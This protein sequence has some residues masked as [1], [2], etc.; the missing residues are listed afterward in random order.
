MPPKKKVDDN[1]FAEVK[2]L[3]TSIAQAV[4]SLMEEVRR[5]QQQQPAQTQQQQQ[6]QPAQTQWQLQQERVRQEEMQRLLQAQ[7]Q[8]RTGLEMEQQQIQ[9][10]REQREQEREQREQEQIQSMME[11]RK[12]QREERE[13]EEEFMPPEGDDDDTEAQELMDMMDEATNQPD[14]LDDDEEEELIAQLEALVEPQPTRAEIVAN[15]Q[16]ELNR[17]R[18]RMEADRAN[19]TMREFLPQQITLEERTR[20]QRNTMRNRLINEYNFSPDDADNM[21]NTNTINNLMTTHPPVA[22][23]T[24][25]SRSSFQNTAA[26]ANPNEGPSDFGPLMMP[27]DMFSYEELLSLG[28]DDSDIFPTEETP[29]ERRRRRAQILR[30]RRGNRAPPIGLESFQQTAEEAAIQA[31]PE[32]ANPEALEYL[33]INVDRNSLSTTDRQYLDRVIQAINRG[34]L[35]DLRRIDKNM[36]TRRNRN[37]NTYGPNEEAIA[38]AVRLAQNR[39]LI[40]DPNRDSASD[41]RGR[42]FAERRRVRDEAFASAENY[43]AIKN[44]GLQYLRRGI[45]VDSLSRIDRNDFDRMRNAIDRESGSPMAEME[46]IRASI[47]KRLRI[48]RRAATPIEDRILKT[49]KVVKDA[50]PR[51]M[52]AHQGGQNRRVFTNEP[53]ERSL[54]QTNLALARQQTALNNAANRLAA[55]ENERAAQRIAQ[56]VQIAQTAQNIAQN[57][58]P[59]IAR[60]I[61]ADPVIVIT[62]GQGRGRSQGRG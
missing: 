33:T 23:N 34:D 43:S 3:T 49:I 37:N 56:N 38:N 45:D 42:T 57:V 22:L 19:Q 9:Q 11:S 52:P 47:M 39:V 28:I 44:A 40:N 25:A 54:R 59:Q 1:P 16:E 46:L 30:E 24:N 41:R 21:I 61:T 13:I 15:T 36:R 29:E 7:E 18:L 55:Q 51:V 17:Q 2:E 20:R 4:Q 5:Q 6:Q 48:N 12:R 27:E 26:H 31:Q 10:Q 8:Q 35:V 58:G 53:G 60:P 62:G 32:S 50:A 14:Q